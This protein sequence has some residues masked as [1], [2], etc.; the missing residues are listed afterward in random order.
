[1]TL[2]CVRCSSSAEPPSSSVDGSCSVD[3][4]HVDQKPLQLTL[5]YKEGHRAH[6]A[7]MRRLRQ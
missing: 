2:S 4:F 5:H 7:G 3:L 1:M 6:T